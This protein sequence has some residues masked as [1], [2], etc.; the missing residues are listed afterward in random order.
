VK[1]PSTIAIISTKDNHLNPDLITY[2]A[3][4]ML[5]GSILQQLSIHP[6][7][8]DPSLRL[9]NRVRLAITGQF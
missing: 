9:F 8:L 4:A 6:L 2:D 3:V 1:A 5:P 7:M